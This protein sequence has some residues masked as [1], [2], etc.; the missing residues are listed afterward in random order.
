MKILI[1]SQTSTVSRWSLG[2]DKYFHPSLYCACDNLS[3]LGLKSVKAA[4]GDAMSQAPAFIALPLLPHNI[5][6]S[7]SQGLT[8]W[9]LNKIVDVLQTCCR[10]ATSSYPNLCWLSCDAMH[11][12]SLY[13][14]MFILPFKPFLVISQ[15]HKPSRWMII[16][17]FVKLAHHFA[18]AAISV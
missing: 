17:H 8:Q 11:I 6:V 16:R 15:S 18:H 12:I 4:T 2:M 14:Y 5:P 3:K 10:Q 9:V 1:H 13:H 7:A